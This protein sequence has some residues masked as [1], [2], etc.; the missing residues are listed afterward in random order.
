MNWSDRIEYLLMFLAI[1]LGMLIYY[2]LKFQ[3]QNAGGL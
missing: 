2:E 3:N 1:A